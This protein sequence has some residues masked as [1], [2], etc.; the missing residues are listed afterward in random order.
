M[1]IRVINLVTGDERYY[2]DSLGPIWAVA[3]AFAQVE[4]ND[5]D[6]RGYEARYFPH[7]E[8]S[9]EVGSLGGWVCFSQLRDRL[10]IASKTSS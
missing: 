9:G 7:V 4:R 1:M 8:W 6:C 10:G 3:A 5:W 2:D